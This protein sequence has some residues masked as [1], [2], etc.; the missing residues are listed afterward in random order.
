MRYAASREG[1]PDIRVHLLHPT[2]RYVYE[3]IRLTPQI[4]GTYY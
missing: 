2:Y 3:S 1:P 4:L